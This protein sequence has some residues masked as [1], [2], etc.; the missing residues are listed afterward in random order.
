MRYLDHSGQGDTMTTIRFTS[1]GVDAKVTVD[2]A[3]GERRTLLPNTER[4]M[5]AR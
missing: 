4:Q 2:V 3:E 1:L 5:T